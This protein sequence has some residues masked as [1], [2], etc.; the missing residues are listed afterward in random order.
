[1]KRKLSGKEARALYKTLGLHVF[2]CSSRALR[3]L[4]EGR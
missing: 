3:L 2:G 1:L 4:G